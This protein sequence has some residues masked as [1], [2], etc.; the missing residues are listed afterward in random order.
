MN[1]RLAYSKSIIRPDLREISFF[2]EYDFE[3][4]GS[5][6]SQTP[7][8]STKIH[9]YDLRYEW[10]PSAGEVFSLTLFYK[11]MLYPMEIFALPNRLFE[12]RNDKDAINKG[13]E[14]E[15]RKSLK[16][17]DLPVI[18]DITLYGNTTRLFSTV[19]SMELSFNGTNADYPNKLFMVEHVGPE[20]KRPQSGASNFM[21]N[22][23]INYDHKAVSISGSF[24]YIANR[25][26]RVG[27]ANTGSL[28]EQPMKSLDAQIAVKLM[29]DKGLLRLNA[30]NLLNS[31]YL[32]YINIFDNGTYSPPDGKQPSAKELKYAKGDVIDYVSAPGRTFS[33]S[34]HYNF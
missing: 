28:Y 2:R 20:E 1:L 17:I 25:F 16:F 26:Y 4:G 19:R 6:W 18:R 31:S 21:Y 27:D 10:Y 22:A 3:L 34:F 14:L 15:L 11:K 9:H 5:Y 30:S 32:I 7:I 24:N 23:G 8:V 12:L 33:L 29:K 13:I